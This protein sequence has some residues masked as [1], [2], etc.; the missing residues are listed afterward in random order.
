MKFLLSLLIDAIV[1][2][3]LTLGILW[4]DERLLNIGYFAGWFVGVVNLIGLMSARGQTVFEREYEH[5][6]LSRRC[7]DVLTDVAFIVFAVWSGWYVMSAVYALQA[8]AKAELIAKL[9][10]KLA[11]PSVSEQTRDA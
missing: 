2:V 3:T 5:R 1:A 10:R 6:T 11:A 7:Y 8:A 4:T 9:E